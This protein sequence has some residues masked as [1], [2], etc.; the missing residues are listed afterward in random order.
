MT[1]RRVRERC[2]AAL[3]DV[4][5]VVPF[6]RTTFCRR[7]AERRRRPILLR[8]LDMAAAGLPSGWWIEMP[9]VDLVLHD[10]LTSEYHQDGIVLHEVGH[11][12][13]DHYADQ[14]VGAQ[15][16]QL[17]LDED[18]AAHLMPTI[19]RLQARRRAARHGYSRQEEQEA[20]FFARFVLGLVRPDDSDERVTAVPQHR[21]LLDRLDDTFGG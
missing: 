1:A 7:L 11:I 6:D 9:D 17:A 10:N 14:R 3:A 5:L 21:A 12:L 13:L 8:G 16:A 2:L 15:A 19:G 18:V 4:E 20:E